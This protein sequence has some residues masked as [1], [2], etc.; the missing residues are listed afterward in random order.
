MR[1]A[2]VSAAAICVAFSAA[3]PV[4]AK[5]TWL[6]CG[7]QE[8][9]LDSTKERFSLA[10]LGTIYQKPATFS[11]VQINFEYQTLYFAY[12]SGLKDA[13][14]IDRKTLNYTLTHLQTLGSFGPDWTPKGE[15]ETGKCSIIKTPPT[16][17]NQI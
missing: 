10:K 14:V 12:G 4:D 17:G 2:L 13:W 5:S 11:P 16:A 9:N 3:I 8:I 7:S 6:K 15:P 1:Q